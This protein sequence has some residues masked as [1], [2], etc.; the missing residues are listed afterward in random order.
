MTSADYS[1]ILLRRSRR[2]VSLFIYISAVVL[3]RGA[4]APIL[5][6]VDVFVAGQ[7]GVLEYR[8]PGLL[9]SNRGTLIAFCDGR[10]R[11]QGDPPNDI[12]LVMKRSVDNGKSWSPLR[13]LVDNGL[14]AAAD[15]CGLVDRQTG[16]LW[17][18]SVYA[19]VGVGSYN[20]AD[21]FTGDVFQFKA[22]KSD[23]DGV[24][25][26]QPIDF[27]PMVKRSNW[28]AGST[29]V[30]RGIQMR[31]GRLILPRYNADYREPR[32]TP[33]T[34]G[35]FVGYSDDHGKTWQ[36]GAMAYVAGPGT[37]ECQVAELAD[38]SLLINMRGMDGNHRK[39][40]RSYDGGVTWSKGIE[41]A[42]LIEPRC[43]GSLQVLTDTIAQDKNRLL[44]ANPASLE[45]KNMAVRLSY[46]EGHT[47]S[48]AKTL[49]AG[50]AA[51]SCLTVLADLTA[52][53]LYERGE[54][55]AYE[56]ITF[57]RFNVEWLTAGQDA[58]GRQP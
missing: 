54:H 17:I 3:A 32:T 40:A 56:K 30:G 26:S 33:A 35:S 6:Q 21:G 51:Y 14:G 38:G 42:T 23:D 29:G 39:S 13:T 9:T 55:S 11:K 19:P 50:P 24:T 4:N 58:I 5:E 44:F 34:A 18:F 25:W 1:S 10:M 8:I 49:H 36:M 16:T 2:I 12:D 22:I 46:D 45:R 37:N 28:G 7:D 53:C 15:S 27:T 41:E 20:A 48:A 52:G 43:Q 57:A 31:N 47:W